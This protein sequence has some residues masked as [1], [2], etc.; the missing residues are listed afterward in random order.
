MTYCVA[1]KVKQGLVFC[2]D[3]RTNAGADQVSTY[4][5]MY[6]WGVEGNR[7]LVLLSAGN[8]AT[9]QSVIERIQR[10]VN[11]NA[12]ESLLKF[13]HLSDI[14]WYIGEIS[15]EER[16]RFATEKD[17]ATAGFNPE[18]TFILGGQ[19]GEEES[20]ICLIYP[21]G[22][23][24]FASTI[25]PY[26]QIGETKYGK[27]I[28]DRIIRTNTEIDS[29]IRCTLV[30]MDSTMRSNATVGPPMEMCVYAEGSLAAGCYRVFNGDDAYLL[31]LKK[32]W[33]EKIVSA[34]SEL[35]RLDL[36]CSDSA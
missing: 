29:A 27:P 21:E 5:K 3:S 24:I 14:A 19:I 16:Q 22:N 28:L 17:G 36:D 4:R 7:Q 34:F 32:A 8:L 6:R 2:S 15:V 26:L 23:H 33:D 11:D 31:E 10:D 18:A 35:P 20:G 9:T 25:S 13:R 1:I 12:P 30:S